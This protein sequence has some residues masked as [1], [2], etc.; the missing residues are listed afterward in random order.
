M[1]M[2]FSSYLLCKENEG[3]SVTTFYLI[4]INAVSF[5]T[6]GYLGDSKSWGKENKLC[7]QCVLVCWTH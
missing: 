5:K 2:A 4:C 7:A 3:E 1:Q 6:F